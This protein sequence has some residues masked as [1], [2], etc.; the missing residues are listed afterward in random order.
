MALP[1]SM[2]PELRRRIEAAADRSDTSVDEWLER[3]VKRELDREARE[4]AVGWEGI[5]R[6]APGAR[7][8]PLSD[9]PELSDGSKISDAVV[10]DR[11]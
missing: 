3:A 5:V 7:L 10:E 11:R 2:D 1:K 9:P 4:D 6:P 8:T